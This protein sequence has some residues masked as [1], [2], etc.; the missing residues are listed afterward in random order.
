MKDPPRKTIKDAKAQLPSSSQERRNNLVTQECESPLSLFKPYLEARLHFQ[1][2]SRT[3][4]SGE[5][6]GPITKRK[7]TFALQTLR[8]T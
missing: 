4:T 7:G 6:H 2:K 5:M 8:E 1:S 3:T